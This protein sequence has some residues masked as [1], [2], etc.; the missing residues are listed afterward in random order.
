MEKTWYAY[1]HITEDKDDNSVIKLREI[2]LHIEN[3]KY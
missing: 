3:M 2:Y 1:F